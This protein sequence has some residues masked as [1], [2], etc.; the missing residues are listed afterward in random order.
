MR[1]VDGFSEFSIKCHVELVV[2]PSKSFSSVSLVFYILQ[3]GLRIS[4]LSFGD[5]VP[6]E[7]TYLETLKWIALIEAG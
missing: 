3:A 5:L 7:K 1:G 4:N 6:F 2:T